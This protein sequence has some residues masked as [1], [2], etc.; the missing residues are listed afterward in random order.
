MI[1]EFSK[2]IRLVAKE[3][4][5]KKIRDFEQQFNKDIEQELDSLKEKENN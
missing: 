4:D 5:L 2:H 3:E 1:E